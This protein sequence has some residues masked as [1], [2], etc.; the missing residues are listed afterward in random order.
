VT[1]WSRANRVAPTWDDNG[2]LTCDGRTD[3][4][5]FGAST[6]L[7]F[8]YDHRNHLR[9]VSDDQDRTVVA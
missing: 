8:E 9:R 3:H 6:R 1:S 7:H 4:Q 2:N 5:V